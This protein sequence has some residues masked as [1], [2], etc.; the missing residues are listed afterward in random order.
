M[1]KKKLSTYFL[2]ISF[3]TVVTIFSVIVQKSYSNLLGPSQSDD[4]KALLN[5]INPTLDTSI[6]QEIESRPD[7][8]DSSGINFFNEESQT[9]LSVETTSIETTDEA[10]STPS[11]DQNNE[12]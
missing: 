3:F 11:L 6:I 8:I 12:E 2:F 10:S 7:L 9:E 5:K 1:I 4:V